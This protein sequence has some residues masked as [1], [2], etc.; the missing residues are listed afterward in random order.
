MNFASPRSSLWQSRILSILRIVAALV[1]IEH[2]TQKMFNY[3][4]MGGPGPAGPY[5]IASLNGIAGILETF[6]GFA[7]VI[8]LF[9]RPIAF[10]LSGEMAVAYFHVHFPRSVLPIVNR[11][12]TP[13]LLCFI[14]LYLIFAGGGL[15]SVD[16]VLR[17]RR[18]TVPDSPARSAPQVNE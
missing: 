3:P 10:V 9:T 16:A 13:V 11:G 8:G 4:P 15:W 18:R 5:V 7:L 2:G 6:G 17:A 1:L 14:F 12:E